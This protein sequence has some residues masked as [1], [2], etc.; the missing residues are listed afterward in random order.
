MRQSDKRGLEI[1][2][3]ELRRRELATTDVETALA[4]PVESERENPVLPGDAE[5][6][7]AIDA[8]AADEENQH[9]RV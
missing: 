5:M 9:D 2:F 3:D 7:A 6:W 4:Q 1:R 8:S